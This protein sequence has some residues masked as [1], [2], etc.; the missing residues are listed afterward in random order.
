MNKKEY[1]KT[2]RDYPTALNVKEVAEILRICM[3]TAY[4]LVNS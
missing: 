3:K 2:L 1:A 4:K